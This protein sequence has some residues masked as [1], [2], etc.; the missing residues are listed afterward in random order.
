VHLAIRGRTN[1]A[2]PNA[3]LYEVLESGFVDHYWVRQHTV[4]CGG[5][6]GPVRTPG[7]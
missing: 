3:I 2:A 4:G 5:V 6:R 7:G 1:V